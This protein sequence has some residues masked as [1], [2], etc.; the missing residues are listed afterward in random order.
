MYT[1]W[2]SEPVISLGRTGRLDVDLLCINVTDI[3]MS[4][5]PNYWHIDAK[6]KWTPFSR[7]HFQMYFF[8]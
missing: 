2:L 1:Y 6:M 7:R 5:D 8:S 4:Q 3:M